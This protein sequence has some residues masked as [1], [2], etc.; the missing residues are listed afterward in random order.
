[1]LFTFFVFLPIAFFAFLLDFMPAVLI[2]V[3]VDTTLFLPL[4]LLWILLGT[5]AVTL[6]LGIIPTACMSVEFAEDWIKRLPFR[7]L[8][9]YVSAAIM[10]FGG[11]K[12]DKL[13]SPGFSAGEQFIPFLIAAFAVCTVIYI[14]H[15]L[16]T[17]F[18]CQRIVAHRTHKRNAWFEAWANQPSVGSGRN[19][20]VTTWQEEYDKVIEKFSEIVDNQ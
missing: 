5:G 15:W 11:A 16:L 6:L 8:C 18:V 2:A 4:T 12:L 9:S 20:H 7:I 14:G 10:I 3:A 13:I 1:M 19:A 17:R